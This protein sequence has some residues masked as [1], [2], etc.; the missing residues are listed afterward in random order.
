[1]SADGALLELHDVLSQSPRLVWEDV[2]DLAQL[3]I[4]S[5]GPSLQQDVVQEWVNSSVGIKQLG[6]NT[7]FTSDVNVKNSKPPSK[8]KLKKKVLNNV[9]V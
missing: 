7:K 1:M 9:Q 8:F 5:G 4:Q 6:A 2:L 3:L